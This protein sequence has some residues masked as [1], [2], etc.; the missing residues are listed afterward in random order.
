MTITTAA[1]GRR[2]VRRVTRMVLLTLLVLPGLVWAV[3]RLFGWE[4]GAAI[5]VFAFTPYVA[6]WAW[7]P[8]A[9]ACWARRWL[10]AAAAAIAALMLAGCVLPRALPDSDRG[11]TTGIPLTVMTVN[12]F[13]GAADPAAVVQLVRDNDVAVLAVQEFTTQAKEG[14]TAAGLD[15]LLPF[16]ALADEWG[17]TGSGLYSRVPMTATGSNRGGGGGLQEGNLQ[18][19]GTIQPPGAGPLAVQS[20]HV[21]APAAIAAL[22]DWRADLDAEPRADADGMP[23][24]LL[25]DFNATLDHGAVRDLID[26]GYRDAADADG[27]G[28]IG[29]WGPYAG[30]PVPPITL[31]HILVDKRIGVRGVRVFGITHGDHRA[32]IA[33]LTVPAAP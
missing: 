10:I 23:R 29:T 16:H 12:M 14:L 26:S 9:V 13:V 32:V 7:V 11:P 31:D 6:A 2:P 20:A 22:G 1:T 15:R 24:I 8:V 18:A 19:Y 21:L 17:G 28:L 30:R 3:V 5:P 33:S 4:R 25:G 27:E